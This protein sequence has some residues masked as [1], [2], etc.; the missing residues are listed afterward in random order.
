VSRP[1]ENKTP[2]I[3]AI[4]LHGGLDTPQ[5]PR[6]RL[7]DHQ[8]SPNCPVTNVLSSFFFLLSL[9]TRKAKEERI[10]HSFVINLT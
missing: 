3:E 10:F 8:I 6:T 7:L 2:E 9:I 1:T 4:F 5:K